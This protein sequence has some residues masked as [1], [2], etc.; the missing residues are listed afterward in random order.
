MDK[1]CQLQPPDMCINKPFKEH[2]RRENDSR[3]RADN[4]L[5]TPSRKIKKAPASKLA[6]WISAAWKQIP[7]SIVQ[8]SFKI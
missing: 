6:E 7:G 8:Y 4:R 1:C 5:L 2:L 3:L